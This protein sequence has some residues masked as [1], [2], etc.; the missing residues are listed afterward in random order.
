MDQQDDEVRM[1]IVE[2]GERVPEER[3]PGDSRRRHLSSEEATGK[4]REHKIWVLSGTERG[5][6][7][8]FSCCE[9]DR[10]DLSATYLVGADFRDSQM[11]Y[12]DFRGAD[13]QNAD[14]SFSDLRGAIFMGADLRCARL[15][16]ADLRETDLR[17][18]T[19]QGADMRE[20]ELPYPIYQFGPLGS[21]G[22]YLVV[23][24]FRDGTEEWGTGCFRGTRAAFIAAVEANH[25]ENRYGR[26]YQAIIACVDGLRGAAAAPE[27]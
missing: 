3:E 11:R 25:G 6:R 21:R 13:L 17:G 1:E 20:A 12:T 10:R 19:L 18:A 16:G 26:Q 7:A 15:V 9:L 14:L 8:D 27:A 22:D 24:L 5:Q 4:V 2:D 23:K